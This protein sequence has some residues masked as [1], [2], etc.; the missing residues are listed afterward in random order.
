M[1]DLPGLPSRRGFLKGSVAGAALLPLATAH[2]VAQSKT[3]E[4]PLADYNPV[5]LSAD[6]W[7]FVV[8]ACDRLIPAGGDGPGALEC[9]VPVFIDRQLGGEFGKA[10]TWYMQGPYAPD[11]DPKLGFQSPLSPAQIYREA[12]PVFQDWCQ[13][14]HGDSFEKLDAETQTSALTALQ[15][16]DVALNAEL[17]DFFSF[18]LANTKEGYFA[19]PSHGGNYQMQAWAYI[20]F[21]G[22]RGAYSEWVGRENAKYPLGPVA[23]NGDRT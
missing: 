17:R 14:T 19:D 11:A 3:E 6:E 1:K 2:A 13:K 22:A 5:Y 21:P 15:K 9:R 10:E 8:A 23:L 16:G 20:G 18:L 7:S 12:I 4:P